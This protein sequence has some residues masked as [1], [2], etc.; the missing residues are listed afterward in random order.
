MNMDRILQKLVSLN[1]NEHIIRNCS[2]PYFIYV[3]ESDDYYGSLYFTEDKSIWEEALEQ[4]AIN[5]YF[6]YD[7]FLAFK[8]IVPSLKTTIKI[9]LPDET[10]N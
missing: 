4:L 6:M 8:G 5:G 1:R 9:E 3:C 2:N 10:S 7:N